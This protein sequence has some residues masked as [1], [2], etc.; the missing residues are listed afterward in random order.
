M[1]R[2]IVIIAFILFPTSFVLA[3]SPDINTSL[4][5]LKN[6]ETRIAAMH[7]IETIG[8]PAAEGLKNII[9]DPKSDQMTRSNTLIML[10]RIKSSENRSY[11]EQVFNGDKTEFNRDSAALAL[12][13]LGDKE[14]IPVLKNGLQDS[15]SRVRMRAVWALATLGDNSSET[16]AMEAIKRGIDRA[17]LMIAVDALEATKDQTLLPQLKAN[18]TYDNPE[19]R[20]YSSIAIKRLE[21]QGLPSIEKLKY[22]KK[23]LMDK[24][25]EINGWAAIELAKDGTPESINILKTIAIDKTNSGNRASQ[26]ALKMLVDQGKLTTEGL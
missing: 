23:M 5:K 12:G 17:T 2:A 26:K 7:E 19:T 9:A 3:Q 4:E 11:L 16:L 1:H 8:A 15:S 21:S 13:Y 20:K 25:F 18:L 6:K 24:Q 14:S 22:L 10:G